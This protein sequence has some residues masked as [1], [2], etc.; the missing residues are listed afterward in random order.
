[1]VKT[2]TKTNIVSS[3]N[4]TAA[5]DLKPSKAVISFLVNYSKALEIKNTKSGEDISVFKN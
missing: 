2:S 5:K 1:M 3:Q 4:T